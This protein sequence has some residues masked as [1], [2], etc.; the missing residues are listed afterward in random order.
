MPCYK[1][2]TDHRETEYSIKTTF[3][4]GR[5]QTQM[6]VCLLPQWTSVAIPVWSTLVNL[7]MIH[8]SINQ[9]Q[10]PLLVGSP[11]PGLLEKPEKEAAR[12]MGFTSMELWPSWCCCCSAANMPLFSYIVGSLVRFFMIRNGLWTWLPLERIYELC[13]WSNVESTFE[14]TVLLQIRNWWMNNTSK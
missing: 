14:L 4:I 7:M 9:S 8:R 12:F 11:S 3:V 2:V 13:G 10:D 1:P 6:S 5:F